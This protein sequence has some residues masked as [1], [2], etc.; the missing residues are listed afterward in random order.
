M[1][2]MCVYV[3]SHHFTVTRLTPRG[4]A[5]VES[6][7]KRYVQYGFNRSRGGRYTRAALKVFASATN[8]RYE[9]RFHINQYKDFR[10]LL[11]SN[12]I[13]DEMVETVHVPVPYAEPVELKVKPKWQP[14][15]SQPLVIDYMVQPG[16]QKLVELQTGKERPQ[17]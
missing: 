16:F 3:F 4:R 2:E 9:Y 5:A 11:A 13:S 12:Y 1:A 10:Q 7:A 17:V 6:F 8:D 15:E 14:R